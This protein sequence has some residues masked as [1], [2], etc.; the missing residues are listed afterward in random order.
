MT[1]ST[2]AYCN[3]KSTTGNPLVRGGALELRGNVVITGS[4]IGMSYS[5]ADRG[6]IDIF[7][8]VSPGTLTTTISNSTITKNVSHGYYGGLYA[9][10]GHVNINNST[11]VLNQAG[12]LTG[13]GPHY[14]SP[15]VA[16][17][18]FYAPVT[19][20]LQSTIIANNSA[21]GVHNDLGVGASTSVTITGS[22]N[23]VRAYGSGVTLPGGQGN[24]PKGTCPMLGPIRDNGGPTLTHALQSGSLAI[25]AGNNTANDPHTG[26]PS[27]YDQRGGPTPPPD[28]YP[29]VSG[30]AADIGAYELQGSDIV[31]NA[32][33][34]TGCE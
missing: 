3:A 14:Y 30:I 20:S 23:L 7:N 16:I 2:I 19:L 1:D 24:L 4:V 31:F 29:R 15:G 34:E 13:G 28:G 33:F 10:S 21:N 32:E 9:N 12:G 18:S 17:G 5:S 27:A 11:I 22:N 6:G 26:V 8:K 25:D